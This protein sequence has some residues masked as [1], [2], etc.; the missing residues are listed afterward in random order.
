MSTNGF[1]ISDQSYEHAL[2]VAEQDLAAMARATA[3]ENEIR[4]TQY[5]I[6]VS[7]DNWSA[8]ARLRLL[9]DVLGTINTPPA[10]ALI[11]TQPKPRH[12]GGDL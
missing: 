9:Q 11:C 8:V 7:P 2:Q 3:V 4:F 5:R 6:A 10:A 12:W 1:I